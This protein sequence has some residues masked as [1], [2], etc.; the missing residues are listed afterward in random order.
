[1][2]NGVSATWKAWGIHIY[3]VPRTRHVE[4]YRLLSPVRRYYMHCPCV[5]SVAEE[6]AVWLVYYSSRHNAQKQRT[7]AAVGSVSG[8]SVRVF[9]CPQPDHSNSVLPSDCT[10]PRSGISQASTSS[11][12]FYC[13]RDL[14]QFI[15]ITFYRLTA[16]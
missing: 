2:P 7:A 14:S 4:A 9:S 15:P 10:L 5:G 13:S 1:M 12:Q 11:T 6:V 3:V 16:Q 8:C